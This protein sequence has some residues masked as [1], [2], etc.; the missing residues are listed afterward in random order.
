MK[1]G[2]VILAAGQGTRMKSRLPKVLHTLAGR[3]LL[4]HVMDTAASL[5]PDRMVVVYGHG[6]EQVR[7]ALDAPELQ[8]VEQASRL[9]TGHAVQ[10]AIPVLKDVDQVLILYGDVPLMRPGSLQS[11]VEKAA[12]GFG[13]MTIDLDD[14]TGYGRILR[15]EQ[16]QV[17]GIVEEKDA[18]PEQ[19]QIR[20]VNTGIML[21]EARSLERWL[22]QITPQNAQGEYYLT[23]IVALAVAE[24]VE[25]AVAQPAEAVEAEGV[26]DRLQLASLERVYQRWQA[27]AL[28]RGG[29]T[30]RDPNRFDL[31]GHLH[32]G[33]DVS[34]DVNVVVEGDVVLGDNVSVGANTVLRN[35]RVADNTVIRENCVIEDAIIGPDSAIGPF[36]RIRPGTEL[37]GGAHVG[38]FVEIKNSRIGLGSKVNHLTY[39]GDTDMGAGV[40]IGAGTI[41]CNYDGAFKHR[42][43]IED[44]AFIGSNTALVAPVSVGEDATIG[45]GSVIVK[46]APPG[47][48]TLARGK[49]VTIRGWKRPK[50]ET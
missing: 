20:E 47:E 17:Q 29:V 25:I 15:N 34:L 33:L 23:D 42:T 27:D 16:G 28:M 50:K 41:T 36:S 14:P 37:V 1:L 39:I 40:N 19:L 5:Q 10:Q 49:Q 8:W 44:K 7:E 30:L 12:S 46:D 38:N 48:L 9:G 3:P 18:T 26:N 22:E 4:A 24:G 31:R 43:R 35:V 32:T 13:L 45:A 11:L 2:I 6:G 21:V